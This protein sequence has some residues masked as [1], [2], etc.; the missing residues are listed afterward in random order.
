M[1]LSK[2]VQLRRIVFPLASF[3][4]RGLGR[5]HL[6]QPASLRSP[7]RF[8]R[9][10]RFRFGGASLRGRGILDPVDEVSPVPNERVSDSNRAA[11]QGASHSFS[12]TSGTSSYSSAEDSLLGGLSFREGNQQQSRAQPAQQSETGRKERL[13][14]HVAGVYFGSAAP[15]SAAEGGGSAG[16]PG[17]PG[18]SVSSDAVANASLADEAESKRPNALRSIPL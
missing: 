12:A 7:R 4:L 10:G 5:L 1:V 3:L 6:R 13:D 17:V 8:R 16:V 14:A 9:L 18:V 11:R 2:L 15:P